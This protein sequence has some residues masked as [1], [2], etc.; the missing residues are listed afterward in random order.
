[1][2]WKKIG[3][4]TLKILKK[5]PYYVPG[6]GLGTHIYREIKERK[7]KGRPW[8]NLKESKDRRALGNYILQTGYLTLAVSWK[9][10]LGN[11][12]ATG[13]WNPFHLISKDKIEQVEEIPKKNKKVGRQ[14]KLEKTI[15]YEESLKKL[16]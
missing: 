6:V 12:I 7:G 5:V 13:E 10:W 11:G 14:N 16:D 3:N 15:D 9:V 4:Y 8:Y 1:M 2:N